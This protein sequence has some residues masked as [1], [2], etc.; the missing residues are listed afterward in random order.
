MMQAAVACF[1]LPGREVEN[2]QS[3]P[4]VYPE[5][6]LAGSDTDLP[7]RPSAERGRTTVR[8]LLPSKPA[9]RCIAP[10]NR[11]P[12]RSGRGRG[13]EDWGV[14]AAQRPRSGR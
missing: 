14:W 10:P 9:R 12:C 1:A 8:P 7:G 13:R 4:F 5:R 11:P 6:L 3:L 2:C